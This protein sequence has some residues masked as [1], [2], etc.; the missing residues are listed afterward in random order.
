M[1]VAQGPA[2]ELLETQ[3]VSGNWGAVQGH[4]LVE[5]VIQIFYWELVVWSGNDDVQAGTLN[6]LWLMWNWYLIDDA[7]VEILSALETVGTDCV[8]L[9]G[10]QRE[11]L[12]DME[13]WGVLEVE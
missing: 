4:A 11:E 13:V 5:E 9:E 7:L 6:A 1:G 8:H 3:T 10:D 2:E 12:Q